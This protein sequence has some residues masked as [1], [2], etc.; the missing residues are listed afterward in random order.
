MAYRCH[1][2]DTARNDPV[3]GSPVDEDGM[4]LWSIKRLPGELPDEETGFVGRDAELDTLGRLLGSARL[5]TVTGQAGVGKTRVARR[6]AARAGQEFTDGVC[7]VELA[8]LRDGDLLPHTV[9]ACLRLPEQDA[10]PGADMVADYLSARRLL[11]VLDTCE[12]VISECGALVGFLLGAAPGVKVLTTSRQPLDLPEEHVFRVPPLP[13][14]G[15]GDAVAAPGTA[16]ELF[17]KRAAAAVPGSPSPRRAAITSSVHARRA[18]AVGP[19]VGVRGLVQHPCGR[20]SLR[21]RLA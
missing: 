7:F 1:V 4:T 10:R 18:A 19:A 3:N 2:T 11:L 6:A 20:R 14:P 8:G 5:V 21:L 16:V 15:P 13:V 12:H 9:A 17:A